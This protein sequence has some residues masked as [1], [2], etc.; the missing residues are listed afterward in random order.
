MALTNMTTSDA[1]RKQLWEEKLFRDTLLGGYFSRFLGEGTT[2]IKKGM[3]V[4]PGKTY[5]LSSSND[6][7][8]AKMNLKFTGRTKTQNGDKIT[9]GL[10][11][12]IDAETNPGV[13]SGQTLEGKEVALNWFDWDLELQRYRQGISAAEPLSWHRASFTIPEEAR[14]ALLN[15]GT[16]KI[17]ILCRDALDLSPTK[18]FYK[19]STGVSS[20]TSESTAKTA[21]TLAD[22]KITTEMVS[23]MKTWAVT[24]GGRSQIPIRPLKVNGRNAYVMLVHPDVMYD[25]RNDPVVQ[26]AAGAARDRGRDNPLFANADWIWD[27]VAIHEFE[28]ITNGTNAGAAS[29]V[30]FAKCHFLGAQSL[31]WAWGQKPDLIEYYRDAME[32]LYYAW[33]MTAAVGKPNFDSADYGT[34][35]FYVSRTNVA[36]S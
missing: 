21:L 7:I 26:Q 6:M 34:V 30:P 1:L 17:D 29:D 3:K 28:L 22:S 24:G 25:W 15:W 16:E 10:V 32:E 20:T 4:A 13:I 18:I 19:T 36:G 2:K 35:T 12:R 9:F 27:D 5:D 8:Q 23:W 33:R 14:V 31:C 11:P